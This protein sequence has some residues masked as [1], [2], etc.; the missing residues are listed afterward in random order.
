MNMD[1]FS[2]IKKRESCRAY[3]EQPVEREKLIACMEAVQLAPSACNSQ[4]WRMILVDD[5]QQVKAF[6]PVM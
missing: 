4:P 3:L 6:V 2:L 5:P 1:F